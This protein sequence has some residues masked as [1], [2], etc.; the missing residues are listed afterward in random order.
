MTLL[1]SERGIEMHHAPWEGLV[2]VVR[3]RG[4]CDALIVDAPYSA[5]THK[6]HDGAVMRAG[7]R[8]ELDYSAWTAHE[9]TRFV[10]GWHPLVRGWMV[11]LTD[12]ELFPRWRDELA[13]VGRQT[14]A[15]VPAIVRGMTVRLLGDGPSSWTIH[16]AVA[17]PRTLAYARWGTLDGAYVGPSEPQ[18]VVGGK[19][20]WLMRALV[21]DYTRPGDLVADPC[22][23]GGTTALACL[24]EGRRCVTG[25][26]SLE[27]AEIAA[28]RLRTMPTQAADGRT[29]ALFGST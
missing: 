12:D 24:L 28:E 27:H 8:R 18:P 29:L 17:R 13:H 14:F 21:R 10:S 15:D 2:E 6:G 22:A 16:C 26:V 11:S 20:L 25:D 7:A 1:L 5:R 9:I 23:G 3:E 19:P 4:G